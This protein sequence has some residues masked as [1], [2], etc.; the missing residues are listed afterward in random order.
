MEARSK[1][2][3][4]TINADKLD[5]ASIQRYQAAQEGVSSS[6]S[7][8]LA[9]VESY[10]DLKASKNFLE[11]QQQLESTENRIAVA[12]KDFN[13]SVKDYNSY[14]RRFPQKNICRHVRF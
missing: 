3:S 1:A 10:P 11:L 5:P 2:T 13:E 9:V 7:R 14:I 12:R 6:L 8:L 4:V